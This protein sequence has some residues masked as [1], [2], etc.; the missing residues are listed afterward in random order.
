MPKNSFRRKAVTKK[1]PMR[2]RD[3]DLHSD[4]DVEYRIALEEYW[5]RSGGSNV[6]KLQTLAKYVP[7]QYLRR[8]LCKY[9]LFQKMLTVHGSIIECGVLF[10]GCLMTWAQLSAIYEPYNHQRRII[11]FDT[12]SGF[13]SIDDKD[14]R[15]TSEFMKEGGLAV[16][17]EEDLMQCISLYDMNRFVNHVPKVKLV[18]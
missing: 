13:P 17:S 15:G 1:D 5:V 2:F 14:A 9:Q 11:G 7:S 3:K 10:G 8:F 6:E 4:K 16:A 18:K 12:F